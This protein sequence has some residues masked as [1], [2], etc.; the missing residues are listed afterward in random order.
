MCITVILPEAN[1]L[2]DCIGVGQLFSSFHQHTPTV[3]VQSCGLT[4]RSVEEAPREVPINTP[5][6]YCLP[7][8]RPILSA[9]CSASN[10]LAAIPIYPGAVGAV[11]Y[12]SPQAW[13]APAQNRSV[14]LPYLSLILLTGRRRPSY[15]CG[16]SPSKGLEAFYKVAGAWGTHLETRLPWTRSVC[17]EWQRT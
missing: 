1:T 17:C 5:L 3:S 10:A 16:P 2:L 14:D 13:P 9:V 7:Q 8:L 12:L 4:Y 15:P 6:E 11:H